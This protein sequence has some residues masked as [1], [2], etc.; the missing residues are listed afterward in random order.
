MDN[1]VDFMDEWTVRAAFTSCTLFRIT[2][3]VITHHASR[4]THFTSHFA[5]RTSSVT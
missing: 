2:H 3:H 4:I 5:L 1:F